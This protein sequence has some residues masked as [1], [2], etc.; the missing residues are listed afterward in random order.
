MTE[1]KYKREMNVSMA[2]LFFLHCT[3]LFTAKYSTKT[4]YMIIIMLYNVFSK[5][6]GSIDEQLP[7]ELKDQLEEK[8]PVTTEA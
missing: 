1:Q 8:T 3:F 2:E 6:Q 7:Q 5:D 4:C